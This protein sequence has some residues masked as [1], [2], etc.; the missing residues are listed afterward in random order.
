[1]CPSYQTRLVSKRLHHGGGSSLF[2]LFAEIGRSFSLT[3]SISSPL[4]LLLVMS[5]IPFRFK[6]DQHWSRAL[7]RR[8]SFN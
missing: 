8:M 3:F 5:T 2:Y 1:M 6:N 4:L 7:W